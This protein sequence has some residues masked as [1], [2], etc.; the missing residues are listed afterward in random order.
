[1]HLSLAGLQ[2]VV[3]DPIDLRLQYSIS[4]RTVHSEAGLVRMWHTSTS[5]TRPAVLP[6]RFLNLT[7][8]RISYLR[9]PRRR[10]E[11]A[12][13]GSTELYT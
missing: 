13:F 9:G 4:L 5:C 8:P 12:Y 7:Q 1:M 11:R 10:V 2:R 6:N 3:N